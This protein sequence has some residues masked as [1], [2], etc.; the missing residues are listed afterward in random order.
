ME[1]KGNGKYNWIYSFKC[2]IGI[3]NKYKYPNSRPYM[4]IVYL[5]SR[6]YTLVTWPPMEMCF[7]R[8]DHIVSI[9]PIGNLA[10]NVFVSCTSDNEL[11]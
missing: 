10:T 6:F 1:W 9:F 8:D 4:D 3:G 5:F 7:V 11:E 2:H